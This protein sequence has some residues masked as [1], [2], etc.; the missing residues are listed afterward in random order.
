MRAQVTVP[1]ASPG[2][3][4]V[5]FERKDVWDVRWAEDNPELF[6]MM[7]K[8]RMYVFKGLVAEVTRDTAHAPRPGA[9]PATRRTPRDMAHA[10]AA[11]GA[12][13]L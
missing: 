4:P 9:R 8:T 6:A 13:V 7:E 1:P 2:D 3:T 12:S 5:R 10:P 11:R